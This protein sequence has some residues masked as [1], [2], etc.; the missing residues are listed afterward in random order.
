MQNQLYSIIMDID[1]N[2]W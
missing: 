1:I 2:D